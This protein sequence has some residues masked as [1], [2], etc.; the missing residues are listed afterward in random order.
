MF[1]DLTNLEREE[2]E[3]EIAEAA[4][5]I[6]DGDEQY[7]AADLESVTGAVRSLFSSLPTEGQ[8]TDVLLRRME[9]LWELMRVDIEI[10]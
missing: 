1:I 10:V 7:T 6:Q 2:I 4:T 8:N 9:W 3:E 5:K